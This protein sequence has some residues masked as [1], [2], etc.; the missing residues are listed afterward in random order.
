VVQYCLII[1]ILVGVGRF[2]RGHLVF[3]IR[4]QGNMVCSWSCDIFFLFTME[5][6]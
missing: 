2:L 5:T 1:N 3:S 6:G 4:W